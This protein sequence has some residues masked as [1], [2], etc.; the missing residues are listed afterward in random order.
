MEDS[1][2]LRGTSTGGA[3]NEPGQVDAR[4]IDAASTARNV[5]A[6]GIGT[7]N[8]A[9]WNSGK[10]R[11]RNIRPRWVAPRPMNPLERHREARGRWARRAQM[12]RLSGGGG[13]SMQAMTRSLPPHSGQVS[14]HMEVPVSRRTGSPRAADIDLKHPFQALCP[15]DRMSR[16]RVAHGCAGAASLSAQLACRRPSARGAGAVRCGVFQDVAQDDAR[17]Q[18][19]VVAMADKAF[20]NLVFGGNR[21]ELSEGDI[22]RDGRWNSHGTAARNRARNN[23]VN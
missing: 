6:T 20:E 9:F 16:C 17:E 23:P 13:S 1:A 7:S 10:Y 4:T 3:F 18:G 8:H 11:W 21:L 14:M 5:S 22:L 19:A 2:T 12:T 15:L